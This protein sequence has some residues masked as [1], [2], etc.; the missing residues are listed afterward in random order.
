MKMKKRVFLETHNIKNR[1]TGFGVFNYSLIKG[2]SDLET[3]DLEITISAKDTEALAKEFKQ[4]FKYKKIFGFN[5]YPLFRI[6]KK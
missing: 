5:R 1:T 2:L 4:K 6:W 3:T